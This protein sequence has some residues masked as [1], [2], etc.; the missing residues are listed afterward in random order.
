M[1]QLKAFLSSM[2]ST[3]A[4][5]V[6][7]RY[8]EFALKLRD[9]LRKHGEIIAIDNSPAVIEE[10]A[11]LPGLEGVTFQLMD[12]Q[13][14]TYPNGRFDLVCMSNT[15][16]HLPDYRPV[17]AEM[18][19]VLKPGGVLLINEMVSDGQD[20]AQQTHTMLHHLGGEIDTLLGEYHGRTMTRQ[21]LADLFTALPLSDI[22]MFSDVETDPELRVKLEKKI[23]K[24][25][26]KVLKASHL[27]EIE[28]LRE[29]ALAVREKF[30]RDGIA[31]STQFVM[32]G[33]KSN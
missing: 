13:H 8:G 3:A 31:R 25:G 33:K 20:A 2:E 24:I 6:G 9:G 29:A 10:A 16:H 32:V 15:L 17:L 4:L 21:E 19:R 28:H 1:K 11:K 14:L 7:S 26:D 22:S 5:D 27:P 30:R 12:A 23:A 18:L